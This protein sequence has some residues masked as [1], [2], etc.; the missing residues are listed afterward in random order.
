MCV[1]IGTRLEWTWPTLGLALPNANWLQS[2]LFS[3]LEAIA[4]PGF[5]QHHPAV[6]DCILQKRTTCWTLL[7][8]AQYFVGRC[9]Q[10]SLKFGASGWDF[11]TP[12]YSNGICRSHYSNV[13]N[14]QEQHLPVQQPQLVSSWQTKNKMGGN[15]ILSL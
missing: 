4:M 14:K 1:R 5:W 6:G 10:K 2:Q 12:T 3:H 13:Q 7:T 8:M 9:S 15:S 11:S